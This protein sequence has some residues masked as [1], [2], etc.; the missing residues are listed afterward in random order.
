[1]GSI[2]ECCKFVRERVLSVRIS[3][4]VCVGSFVEVIVIVVVVVIVAP[5]LKKV[6]GYCCNVGAMFLAEALG[7]FWCS[8]LRWERTSKKRAFVEQENERK[9]SEIT[10]TQVD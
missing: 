2:G 4:R 7:G 1:M 10:T 5:F 9:K 3:L 6:G 8:L